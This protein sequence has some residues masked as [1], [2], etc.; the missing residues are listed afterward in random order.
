MP[1]KRRFKEKFARTHLLSELCS[2]CSPDVWRRKNDENLFFLALL[3]ETGKFLLLPFSTLVLHMLTRKILLFI[4]NAFKFASPDKLESGEWMIEKRMKWKVGWNRGKK[5][6][7]WQNIQ[8]RMIH[9]EVSDSAPSVKLGKGF[10]RYA[11]SWIPY[12]P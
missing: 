3:L 12:N 4:Q 5:T 1:F 6:R 2:T 7:R 10:Y 9:K 8:H 11:T